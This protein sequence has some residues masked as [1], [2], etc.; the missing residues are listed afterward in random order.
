[1][2]LKWMADRLKMATWTHVAK[3]LYP[4]KKQICV[5]T[6]DDPFSFQWRPKLIDF[7]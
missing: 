6:Q 5:K 4:L 3:R 2:T 1:M 7:M